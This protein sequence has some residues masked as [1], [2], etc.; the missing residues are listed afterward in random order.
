MKGAKYYATGESPQVGD[1]VAYG[2]DGGT[3]IVGGL[4]K[5]I[6]VLGDDDWKEI[7]TEVISG[8]C[9]GE[10]REGGFPFELHLVSR[11]EAESQ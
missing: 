10:T 11:L 7:T 5:V 8:P 2:P 3:N 4:E 9:K 1:V 6:D